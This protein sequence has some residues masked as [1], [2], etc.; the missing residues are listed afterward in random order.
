MKSKLLI[1]ERKLAAKVMKLNR[2]ELRAVFFNEGKDEP[3]LNRLKLSILAHN[4]HSE[5]EI[6]SG[7]VLNS[8]LDYAA[9]PVYEAFKIRD[10]YL[11]TKDYWKFQIG[12]KAF[13]K[14]DDGYHGTKKKI[15]CTIIDKKPSNFRIIISFK[16]DSHYIEHFGVYSDSLE[17]FDQSKDNNEVSKSVN[18]EEGNSGSFG[19]GV[20]LTNHYS[21]FEILDSKEK[22]PAQYGTDD[23][24]EIK[25][26]KPNSNEGE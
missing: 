1:E 19:L 16:S 13:L 5:H 10:R 6:V 18:L 21:N 12:D 17:T 8:L 15:P 4:K 23:V 7:R 26:C 11:A 25:Q 20:S 22:T 24:H 2:K 9:D 14:N 3:K